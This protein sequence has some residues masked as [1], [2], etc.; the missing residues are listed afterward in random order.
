MESIA[1]YDFKATAPDELSFRKSDI[2]KVLNL[3]DDRNWCRAEIDGRMGLVPKNYI[4]LKAHDWYHG[5]ISR[6]KA[7]QSLNKPH[8]PDGAFLIRESESS[9]GDFSLSVK[10]GSAVQHFKVLRDGAGKYFLWVVK[11]SSLNELIKYHREQSISRTQQIMLVDL[12]VE[13][14]KVQAAYDFRRQE[15]GEL[16]FCQGDIITVTEWMDKNWWRGSVNNC[17]GIFPS[18]HVIVPPHIAQKMSNEPCQVPY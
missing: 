8:Y 9:P 12:P 13:N 7:E 17:T 4:E 6:V 2:L 10:Y 14:F 3:E 5:K 1:K 11:F 16:E 18:N 15:P